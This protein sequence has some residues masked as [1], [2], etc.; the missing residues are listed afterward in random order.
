MS[1]LLLIISL[2][3]LVSCTLDHAS[4]CNSEKAFD[5]G[6]IDTVRRCVPLEWMCDSKRDCTNGQVVGKQ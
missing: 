3:R 2:V 6:A 5:C 1:R 4:P